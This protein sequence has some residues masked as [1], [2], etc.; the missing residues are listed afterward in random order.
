MTEIESCTNVKI[1]SMKI[2]IKQRIVSHNVWYKINMSGITLIY[3]AI[4][5]RTC[6]RKSKVIKKKKS[7]RRENFIYKFNYLLMTKSHKVQPNRK[8][9]L[10]QMYFANK[11]C[12][13]TTI[14]ASFMFFNFRFL[15]S[16]CGVNA[17]FLPFSCFSTSKRFKSKKFF[18]HH[19]HRN[20]QITDKHSILCIFSVLSHH[21]FLLTFFFF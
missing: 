6:T 10:C 9:S 19:H 12:Y 4:Q 7:R 13:L 18:V 2:K 11:S 8:V 14:F 20:K 1:N 21:F 3:F 17:N 5:F 15:R 16:V